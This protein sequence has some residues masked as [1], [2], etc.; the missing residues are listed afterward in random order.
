MERLAVAFD[1]LEAQVPLAAWEGLL[2]SQ[3]DP[4]LGLDSQDLDVPQPSHDALRE[5]AQAA[6]NVKGE[7]WD[8][9]ALPA[10]AS[11][12]SRAKALIA[13][14][15][16]AMGSELAAPAGLAYLALLRVEG[17]RH[18]WGILF[19]PNI[20]RGVLRALR[21][22]RA[23]TETEEDQGIVDDGDGDSDAQELLSSLLE[24]LQSGA[25]PHEVLGLVVTE[26]SA[27]VLH[28]GHEVAA[29]TAARAL[30]AAVTGTSAAER[31]QTAATV[32]R[33]VVPA[34][35]MTQDRVTPAMS[36]PPKKQILS[37]VI[38][39]ELMSDI[40][41]GS[42]SLLKPLAP[43][44][45]AV[46]QEE[47]ETGHAHGRGMDDPLLA[48]LQLLCVLVPDRAEWRAAACESAMLL[49][50]DGIAAER[51][52]DVPATI[53]ARF[54]AFAERLLCSEQVSCRCMAVDVLVLSLQESQ[55]L[56]GPIERAPF[57][58]RLLLLLL[59]R[60][61]DVVPTVRSRALTGVATAIGS[62]SGYDAGTRL[63]QEMLPR[64]DLPGLFRHA[65]MDS[66]A[67]NRR[68]AL[69]FLEAALRVLTT[70][71]V[72]DIPAYF[73]LNL[74]NYLANDDSVMVRKASISSL[75]QLRTVASKQCLQLWSR[76][77]LPLV[78]D[79][80][81]TI[82]DRALDE[83]AE[84]ILVPLRTQ[85][86][87][88]P[89]LLY[90][91]DPDGTEYLQR[92]LRLFAKRGQR[93]LLAAVSRSLTAA[94]ESVVP[95]DWPLALWPLLAEFAAM[96]LGGPA[97][98][99]V[100]TW[101][102]IRDGEDRDLSLGSRVLSVLE[103]AAP[104]LAQWRAT[105]LVDDLCRRLS[106]FEAPL[107]QIGSMIRVVDAMERAGWNLVSWRTD[108]I[109][110]IEK[111][112]LTGRDPRLGCCIAMLGDLALCDTPVSPSAVAAIQSIAIE[113]E[114]P[115]LRGHA[116]ATL[117]KLCLHQEALAK[118]SVELFVLHLS[119]KE[120][121]EVRNNALVV[122]GDLCVQYTS[123]VDRFVPCVADLL[124]DPNAL[125]RRQGAMI[126]CSLLCESYVKFRGVIVHRLFYALSDPSEDV[127][128]LVDVVFDI[129]HRRNANLF[130]QYFM[131]VICALNGWTGHQS[132]QGALGNE[133]FSL[134]SL[135]AR[136]IM[137]YDF[138]LART[139]NEQ[140][141]NVCRQVISFLAGFTAEDLPATRSEQGGQA[142][143][144]SLALMSCKEMRVCFSSKCD[145]EG[146]VAEAA[147][148]ALSAVLKKV[149]CESILPVL[150]HLKTI[151]EERRSP[152]LGMLRQCLREALREFR[153][154]LTDMLAGNTLLAK[155]LAF[156]DPEDEEGT[157]VKRGYTRQSLGSMIVPELSTTETI[158]T[159]GG[160]QIEE[161]RR[162]VASPMSAQRFPVQRSPAPVMGPPPPRSPRQSSADADSGRGL[163]SLSQSSK[164]GEG[165]AQ[166]GVRASPSAQA[167]PLL[168]L[169]ASPAVHDIT[170]RS[171]PSGLI[172]AM[173]SARKERLLGASPSPRGEPFGSQEGLV[174]LAERSRRP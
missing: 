60:C 27:L 55:E 31:R 35:L 118:T 85:A 76:N 87:P 101:E 165:C 114:E 37:R 49:L 103:H 47:A 149:L 163:V 72:P 113:S 15:A 122:L 145:E 142:L 95:E 7:L 111:R 128:L 104:G 82:A 22:L 62:L 70:L 36:A 5:L 170:P 139:T 97:E 123:L 105:L 1:A 25:V 102:R 50:R 90:S 16:H 86:F 110:S 8:W 12:L 18:S 42:A 108:L 151:M 155:E 158:S 32:L 41:R 152:F 121:F 150:L 75:A 148:G 74:L 166:Q 9:L 45:D 99:V 69:L 174:R 109:R 30:S 80:E 143:A 39:L 26:L 33:S 162:P 136:R 10:Q 126:V 93:S 73:D 2:I 84:A 120:T 57:D 133:G 147:S 53:V 52:L 172:D 153:D 65:A 156:D 20:F 115:D 63:L 160:A 88:L 161:V 79:V 59:S 28:P 23:H 164:A 64:I 29:R 54:L 140:K 51:M 83:I 100:D 107:E 3:N 167:S 119:D 67:Y 124:R 96:N 77:V 43:P 171:S 17:A 48:L 169:L 4:D 78:L 44:Q 98:V 56:S 13:L 40:I 6:L 127:R 138:M 117:G 129:L 116:F 131:Q 66:K 58:E 173:M 89:L 81:A 159:C 146:A 11:E 94:V 168:A 134:H 71:K 157:K 34:V 112:L 19:Q 144:D 135:P 154:E 24:F 91:L 130:V 92:A 132:F 106:N 68:A 46:A 14:L 61:C 38:S 137:V 125:L 21:P 141:F